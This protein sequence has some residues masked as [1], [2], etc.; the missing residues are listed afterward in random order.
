[1]NLCTHTGVGEEERC[2]E[3]ENGLRDG[4]DASRILK[5]CRKMFRKLP[6]SRRKV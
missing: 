2:K 5:K 3:R 4:G 6:G 1:M